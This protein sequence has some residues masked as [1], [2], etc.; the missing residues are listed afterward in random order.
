M[1]S[2][3][4]LAATAL[5]VAPDMC[6]TYFNFT[7]QQTSNT[8]YGL[9]NSD[10]TVAQRSDLGLNY[11]PQGRIMIGEESF[12]FTTNSNQT[13]HQ[14]F[15]MLRADGCCF[16]LSLLSLF[17]SP[18]RCTGCCDKL[19][20][21]T[22]NKKTGTYNV[23]SVDHTST[24]GP[25]SKQCGK[26]GCGIAEFAGLDD[27]AMT[28]VAWMDPLLPQPPPAASPQESVAVPQIKTQ[29]NPDLEGLMLGEF[30]LNTGEIIPL[31]PFV[32]NLDNR[33]ATTPMDAGLAS[34]DASTKD[35]WFAC[36]PN[37]DPNQE[38]VCSYPASKA[39]KAAAIKVFS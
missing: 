17:F 9:M 31:R 36:N 7:D 15:G 13:M 11:D 38:A 18:F 35:F 23:A 1:L 6:V 12:S 37:G 4:K 39:E 2:A 19:S 28:A 34:Y 27:K 32:V 5:T 24:F 8:Y 26:Y 25:G 14:G 22:V 10:G 16:V 21:L 33:T 3:L 20:L 30:N 29:A